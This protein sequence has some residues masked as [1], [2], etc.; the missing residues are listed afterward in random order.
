MPEA[1]LFQP[2]DAQVEAAQNIAGAA[3][4][5]MKAEADA[6]TKSANKQYYVIMTPSGTYGL[7]D[8]NS[9]T[10][11]NIM[12]V[13]YPLP[14]LEERFPSMIRNA[15]QNAATV[16]AP[17]PIQEEAQGPQFM[18]QPSEANPLFQP[19]AI[20]GA[21]PTLVVD[22]SLPPPGFQQGGALGRVGRSRSPRRLAFRSAPVAI[23]MP[24]QG[25]FQQPLGPP[26]VQMGGY[27]EMPP[28]EGPQQYSQVVSVRKLG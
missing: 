20:P 28:E 4:N 6:L 11:Q 22:T 2:S 24:Q 26:D 23:G 1:K 9:V 3:L 25:G 12:N 7:I 13:V 18:A 19:G 14:A 17:P 8:E 15:R 16:S 27:N 21:P 10:P 5:T